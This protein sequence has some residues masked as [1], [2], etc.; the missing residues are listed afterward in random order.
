MNKKKQFLNKALISATALAFF[1]FPVIS[2]SC[3][4]FDIDEYNKTSIPPLTSSQIEEIKNSFIFK[5]KPE[6]QDKEITNI[7]RRWIKETG[8]ETYKVHKLINHGEFKN[9]FEFKKHNLG[10]FGSSHDYEFELKIDEAT[11][12]IYIEWKVICVD[13]SNRVDGT[14]KIELEK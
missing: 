1:S 13:S 12:V 3:Q 5:L 10:G 7:W 8:N 9:Y 2:L 11:N 14:G 4:K 6:A